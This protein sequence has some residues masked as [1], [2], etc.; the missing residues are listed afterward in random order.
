MNP[1]GINPS[2][3]RAILLKL[4]H[5]GGMLGGGHLPGYPEFVVHSHTVRLEDC[6][7]IERQ[8]TYSPHLYLYRSTAQ[9]A[10][11]I[12]YARD[13]AQWEAHRRELRELLST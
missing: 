7:L 2:L 11:W 5:N 4:S 8:A 12:V 6:G 13:G 9:G 1:E 3:V 10:Q